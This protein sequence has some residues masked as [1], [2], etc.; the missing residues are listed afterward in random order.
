MS[1]YSR[2]SSNVPVYWMTSGCSSKTQWNDSDGVLTLFYEH[3][4]G[5]LVT[6]RARYVTEMGQIYEF[7]WEN[8][9]A[10]HTIHPVIARGLDI[11]FRIM[12]E[13]PP[14]I[15]K[16][17]RCCPELIIVQW[18]TELK[19]VDAKEQGSVI[20]FNLLLP[21]ICVSQKDKH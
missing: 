11:G 20:K 15:S 3:S 5:E 4:Y 18:E 8:S 6:L 12:N 10:L 9:S 21:K 16:P 14:K 1:N 13:I 2:N 7:S 17:D 19:I